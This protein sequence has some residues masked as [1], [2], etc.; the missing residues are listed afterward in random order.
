MIA[1]YGIS[2][3]IFLLE[4]LQLLGQPGIIAPGQAGI[5]RLIHE[6]LFEVLDEQFNGGLVQRDAGKD[7]V[8]ERQGRLAN[9][10]DVE[11]GLADVL[12]PDP[13]HEGG[14]EVRADQF[15]IGDVEARRFDRARDQVLPVTE[16]VTVVR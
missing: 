2:Q 14:V 3:K 11:G 8:A 9:I 7:V 1:H 5:G 15:P 6:N 12:E 4:I 16:V 10:N 13:G